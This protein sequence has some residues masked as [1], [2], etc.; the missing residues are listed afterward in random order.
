MSGTR[1][2]EATAALADH[3][4]AMN[5]LAATISRGQAG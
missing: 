1:L 4:T 2:A 5:T 3:L